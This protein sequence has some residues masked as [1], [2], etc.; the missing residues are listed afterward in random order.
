MLHA[1]YALLFWNERPIPV[2][3]NGADIPLATSL[4]SD[5]YVRDRPHDGSLR[6]FPPET[7]SSL[8]QSMVPV[9]AVN[10]FQVILFNCCT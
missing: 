6:Y 5:S 10:N 4:T 8:D 1:D 3:E 2:T 9:D 7:T